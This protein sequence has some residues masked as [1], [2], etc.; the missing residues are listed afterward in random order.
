MANGKYIN[1]NYPKIIIYCLVSESEPNMIKYIGI[2]SRRPE[3]RLS[4]HIYEAK[5]NPNKNN[6]T[7]WISTNNFKIKQIILDI[8]E[9]GDSYFWEKHW[10]SLVKTWGFDLVN[11]NNGGGGS[12]K[13]SLEF[14]KWL[15]ERN[16]G[17]K[18]NLGK[19]HSEMAKLKMSKA[20]LGKPSP[21]KGCVV[22]EETK[23]KQSLAKQGKK[24]NATGFKHT[25]ETKNKKRKPIYQLD[26]DGNI[27]KEW[28]GAREA[29]KNLGIHESKITSVCKGNRITTGGFKWKYINL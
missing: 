29:S 15:S 17:N 21:R 27:I 2:T 11:S 20:K 1:I 8:I 22:S 16:K 19:T 4:N 18:Y 7:K 28:L 26:L 10:I 23:I 6:R 3:Y 25:E 24:G 12:N 5:K 9:T 13:K 14:S